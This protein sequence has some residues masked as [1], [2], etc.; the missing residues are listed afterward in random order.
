M[1]ALRGLDGHLSATLVP[2]TW[3]VLVE[4]QLDFIKARQYHITHSVTVVLARQTPVTTCNAGRSASVE[5]SGKAP[6]RIPIKHVKNSE[7]RVTGTL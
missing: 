3:Q 5:I 1:L 6:R 4:Q 7:R 2:V